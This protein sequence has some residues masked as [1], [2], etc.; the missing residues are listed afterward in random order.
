MQREK[1]EKSRSL[2]STIELPVGLLTVY[3]TAHA[4]NNCLHA[5]EAWQFCNSFFFQFCGY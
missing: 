2:D 3:Y 1:T 4:Y 5:A